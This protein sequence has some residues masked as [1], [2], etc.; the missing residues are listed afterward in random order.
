MEFKN[1]AEMFQEISRRLDNEVGGAHGEPVVI[2]VRQNQTV[3]GRRYV[4][5]DKA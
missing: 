1:R 5:V 3:D 2:I 4:L